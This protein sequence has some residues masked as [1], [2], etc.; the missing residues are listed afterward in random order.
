MAP[1]YIHQAENCKFSLFI[2]KGNSFG[3]CTIRCK[4]IAKK[5]AFEFGKL[6]AFGK[7][8]I[9]MTFTDKILFEP[10]QAVIAFTSKTN[11]QF[12]SYNDNDTIWPA[13]YASYLHLNLVAVNLH[14]AQGLSRLI[15]DL[16][17]VCNIILLKAN[18]Q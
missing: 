12:G 4:L 16:N 9:K 10:I 13:F 8:S 6:G 3:I 17:G 1:S 7:P 11:C 18:R 14:H 2:W 15:N 5:S